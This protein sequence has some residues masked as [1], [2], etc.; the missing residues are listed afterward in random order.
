[1][2]K[3]KQ[4]LKDWED[5]YDELK[6]ELGEILGEDYFQ[7]WKKRNK[8]IFL[9]YRSQLF[10]LNRVDL[11]CILEALYKARGKPYKRYYKRTYKGQKD[12]T[13]VMLEKLENKKENNYG[14]QI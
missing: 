2:A 13:T 10:H 11:A 12:F 8:E 7:F 1:M 14:N 9:H 5:F 6:H 4:P 3:K